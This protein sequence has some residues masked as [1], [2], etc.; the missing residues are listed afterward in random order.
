VPPA[1]DDGEPLESEDLEHGMPWQD[2]MS[3]K[4]TD[5]DPGKWVDGAM[6]TPERL[7]KLPPAVRQAPELAQ[8]VVSR[9]LENPSFYEGGV[10]G[11]T[12]SAKVFVG[13]T[14][15]IKDEYELYYIIVKVLSE[16]YGCFMIGKQNVGDTVN[17]TCR[18]KRRIVFW[19]A[20]GPGWVGFHT[21]QFDRDGYEI[22][23]RQRK[24][25]R[26]SNTKVL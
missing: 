16:K 8:L 6:L 4:E 10:F 20:R 9:S 3:R 19:K 14:D 1:D 18:D 11:L 12:G 17:V 25:V 15:K 24:I 13:T 22:Q 21:R 23:V 26:I 2:L 5:L 7:A